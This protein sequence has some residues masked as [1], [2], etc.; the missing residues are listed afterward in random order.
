VRASHEGTLFLDEI[1][2]MPRPSQVALLRVIQE[3][4]VTPVGET[5]PAPVDLRV[6]A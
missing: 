6:V 3:R 2:D 5:R 4:E 1:G